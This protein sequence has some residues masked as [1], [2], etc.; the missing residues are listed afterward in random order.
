MPAAEDRSDATS[1]ADTPPAATNEPRDKT[2]AE[3]RAEANQY[4]AGQLSGERF[5]DPFSLP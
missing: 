2:V 1:A 4:Q 3:D 5:V